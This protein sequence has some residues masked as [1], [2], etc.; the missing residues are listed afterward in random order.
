MCL[1]CEISVLFGLE[2]VYDSY[3]VITNVQDGNY[4]KTVA[5]VE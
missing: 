2:N 5:M 4:E 3:S 1:M